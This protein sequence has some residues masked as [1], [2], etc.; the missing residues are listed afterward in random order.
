ML[1]PTIFE[2]FTFSENQGLTFAQWL[3]T[4]DDEGWELIT[5]LTCASSPIWTNIHAVFKKKT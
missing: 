1:M 3:K 5:I 4:K 2:V